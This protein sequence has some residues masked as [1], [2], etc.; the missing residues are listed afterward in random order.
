MTSIVQ[1]LPK[2]RAVLLTTSP[3]LR[4]THMEGGMTPDWLRECYGQDF[5]SEKGIDI[6]VLKRLETPMWREEH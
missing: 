5:T 6:I 2:P 3:V 4:V 1:L